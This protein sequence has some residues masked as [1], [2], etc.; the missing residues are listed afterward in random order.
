MKLVFLDLN[1]ARV[2]TPVEWIQEFFP[3]LNGVE[4]KAETTS[5][6]EIYYYFSDDTLEWS[7]TL[8]LHATRNYVNVTATL[9]GDRSKII[10]VEAASGY[11]IYNQY[12]SDSD[13]LSQ[14]HIIVFPEGYEGRLGSLVTLAAENNL[15]VEFSPHRAASQGVV[16]ITTDLVLDL[17]RAVTPN[18]TYAAYLADLL[19]YYDS[20]GIPYVL[21][22][23]YPMVLT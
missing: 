4:I 1:A 5:P 3:E 15:F 20:K 10:Q 6:E 2:R 7:G 13:D 12:Y 9:S 8:R 16:R 17:P 22:D 19:R 18:K 23:G 11:T 21:K 14:D